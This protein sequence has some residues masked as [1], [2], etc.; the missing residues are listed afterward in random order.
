MDNEDK[1]QMEKETLFI[2]NQNCKKK[3]RLNVS[4]HED[5]CRIVVFVL[6]VQETKLNCYSNRSSNLF[7]MRLLNSLN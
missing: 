2:E 3:I 6:I 5:H 4:P 1:M 7:L